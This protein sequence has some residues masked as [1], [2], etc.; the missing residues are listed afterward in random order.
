[1]KRRR[2]AEAPAP[3]K[4]HMVARVW[5]SHA[6]TYR[7]A[8]RYCSIDLVNDGET[9][10]SFCRC[11]ERPDEPLVAWT[12]NARCGLPASATCIG[13]LHLSDSSARDA[14]QAILGPLDFKRA[15]LPTVLQEAA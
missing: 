14:L 7:S 3:V 2:K 4:T 15:A 6:T 8:E 10:L 11:V 1:M 13:V 5:M 12:N 9:V